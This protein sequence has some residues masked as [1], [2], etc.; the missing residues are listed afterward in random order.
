VWATCPSA[1]AAVARTAAAA[2]RAGIRRVMVDTL[3]ATLRKPGLRR[4]FT[5]TCNPPPSGPGA[6]VAASVPASR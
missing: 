6:G 4:G 3:P 5:V 2:I 1:G